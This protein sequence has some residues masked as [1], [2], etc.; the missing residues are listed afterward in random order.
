MTTYTDQHSQYITDLVAQEDEAL[1]A[2]RE[3]L[4][5]HDMPAISIKPEEGRFLQLLTAAAGARKAIEIG[6][7][8]GYSGTWIARGLAPGG[9]LITLEKSEKHAAV[10]RENFQ[11]AGVADRVEVRVGDAHQSLRKLSGE[12]P[13]DLCFIDADKT[14][15][16]EYLTWALAHVRPGGIIAAHNAFRGGQTLQA[17]RNAD[18]EAVQQAVERFAREPRLISTIYPAGDGTVIGVV[19]Q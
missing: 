6:A 8:G 2:A 11:R 7:L 13:F 1:R 12:G 10:A 15:Y 16:D 4:L 3:G 18:T 17:E 5:Q 14:G 9:R 19:R